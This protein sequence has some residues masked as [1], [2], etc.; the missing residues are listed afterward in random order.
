MRRSFISIH[1]SEIDEI[2]DRLNYR[3]REMSGKPNNPVL[4]RQIQAFQ[5]KIQQ[6]LTL[7][8]E[9]IERLANRL[10][11]IKSSIFES[12]QQIETLSQKIEDTKESNKSESRKRRAEFDILI[13]RKKA[14]HHSQLQSLQNSFLQEIANLQI[15]FESQLQKYPN[16]K[17]SNRFTSSLAQID[18]EIEKTKIKIETYRTKTVELRKENETLQNSGNIENVIDLAPIEH[19]QKTIEQRQK[20]RYDNLILSREKLQQCVEMLE[21]MVSLHSQEVNEK[22][23]EF[24]TIEEKYN[25]ELNKL[26][27]KQEMKVLLLNGHLKEAEKRT[28]SLSK[29]AHHL[30][31]TNQ[32]QMRETVC[33]LD[34]IKQKSFENPDDLLPEKN[35]RDVLIALRKEVHGMKREMKQKEFLL[36]NAQNENFELK[37][38]IWRLKHELKFSN[39][40][41]KGTQF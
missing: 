5:F 34:K 41:I 33:D 32:K 25:N 17:S 13:S 15:D 3:N 27:E 20:E 26:H 10:T 16:G 8:D 7:L 9:E 6:S 2:R 39:S 11:I 21:N 24:K 29:A 1:F 36:E 28:K 12:R 35:D 31:V 18:E 19:L 22:Q 14:S 4:N 23:I 30:E 37:R 38:E 40:P